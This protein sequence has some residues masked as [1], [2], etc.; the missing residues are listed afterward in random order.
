[1]IGGGLRRAEA[2]EHPDANL[3]SALAEDALTPPERQQVL[4]HLAACADCRESYAMA[5]GEAPAAAALSQSPRAARR[6]W[7]WPQIAAA[8]AAICLVALF[9]R[10]TAPKAPPP[11]EPAALRSEAP[12][13]A[14]PPAPAP[15]SVE[16]PRSVARPFQPPNVPAM[17]KKAQAPAVLPPPPPVSPAEAPSGAGADVA[18]NDALARQQNEATVRRA[19]PAPPPAAAQA[20]AQGFTASQERV[21][22]TASAPTQSFGS[23]RFAKTAK[24]GSSMAPTQSARWGINASADLAGSDRGFVQRSLDGGTTWQTVPVDENVSFRSV[25]AWGATVWAGGSDGALYRSIDNGV[26]WVRIAAPTREAI[27]GIAVKGA[28][29]VTISAASGERWSTENAGQTWQ[30]H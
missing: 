11:A 15:A 12:P 9:W 14:L 27:A 29:E 3:L 7:L 25:A 20:A 30:D 8:A 6:F 4:A 18:L 16:R 2:G 10:G 1:M 17:K 21:Q 5:F 23:R 26:T 19:L 13:A 28:S 24:P 22:V